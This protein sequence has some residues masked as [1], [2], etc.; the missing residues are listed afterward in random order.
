MMITLHW[1]WTSSHECGE[2]LKP[3]R[4]GYQQRWGFCRSVF[5]VVIVD[6]EDDDNEVNNNNNEKEEA[7]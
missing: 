3:S 2:V 6:D 4:V 7:E 1:N 5:R